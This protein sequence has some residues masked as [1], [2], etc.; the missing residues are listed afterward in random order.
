MATALYQQRVGL[1]TLHGKEKVIAPL[2]AQHF[3][4]SLTVT[5]AFDTDSLGTFS[6]EIERELTPKDCAVKKAVLATE[7]TGLSFG[8]G[9][10]GSF[11]PSPYGFGIFNQ[12]L[13]ACYDRQRNESVT[14]CY[15]GFSSAR[16]QVVD[17]IE[18]FDEFLMSTPVDQAVILKSTSCLEKGIYGADNIREIVKNKLGVLL[19]GSRD[20]KEAITI[21][22]D[23]RA[24]HC[25]ERRIHIAKACENLID[26]LKSVC[27]K[28]KSWGFWPDK[29]IPGLT[30]C[31]CGAPTKCVKARAVICTTCNYSETYP[32]TDAYAKQEFCDYC[33]P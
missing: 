1:L 20:F 23:L 9:S 24:H 25:P 8:L 2:L 19:Q 14:G 30:C 5:Q 6:G 27:P 33:N 7:L 16:S 21:S 26:K 28:C 22:Y 18:I 10:E 3:N 12:E 29:T 4:A 11:G 31:E 17:N 32:A 15:S 13:I